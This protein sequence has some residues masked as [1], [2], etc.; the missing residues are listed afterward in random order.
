MVVMGLFGV[1]SALGIAYLLTF[2]IGAF[3]LR[4]YGLFLSKFF[5]NNVYKE[6][7]ESGA[8]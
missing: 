1:F 5:D 2:G 4:N 3:V 7:G 6:Y 8:F